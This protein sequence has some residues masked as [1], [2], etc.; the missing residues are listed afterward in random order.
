MTLEQTLQDFITSTKEQFR[1]ISEIFKKTDEHFRKTDEQMKKTDE[2][3]KRTDEH[4]RMTDHE[5]N[6]L[7]RKSA[8]YDGNWGKLVEAL[9][10]PS[11]L[12][13]FKQRGIIVNETFERAACKLSETEKIEIDILA[14]NSNVVIA[15]EVKTTL[16]R[17][18][19]DRHIEKRLKLFKR[20][21]RQYS[22]YHII[23]AV[24]YIKAADEAD[25][26]AAGK[27]LFTLAFKGSSLVIITNNSDFQPVYF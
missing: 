24:A 13:L 17:E 25:E 22:S 12:E 27:G 21:F 20:F 1:Q 10:K 8:E 16:N 15:I 11:V 2:Q 18:D 26:Y 23:G 5:I 9:V 14:V 6:K 19:V 3:M 4:F 7:I